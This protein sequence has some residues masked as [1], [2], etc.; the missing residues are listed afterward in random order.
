[1]KQNKKRI[2]MFA[3]PNGS[4]KSTIKGSISSDLLGYYINPDEIEKEI[5]D[6]GYFDLK[7]FDL[8]IIP[9]SAMQFFLDSNFLS[10][11][12]LLDDVSKIKFFPSKIDFSRLKINSYFASVLADFLRHQMLLNGK[13]FSFETVMSSVDKVQFLSYAQSLG[14]RTYLY[15]VAT[16]DPEINSDRVRQRV[17]FG[18]HDVPKDKIFSRYYRS[19]DL[20]SSAIKVTNRAYIFDNSSESSIWIAEITNASEI[21]L[22]V[23]LLPEW[24]E[25]YVWNKFFK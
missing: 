9:S 20:L 19:L 12:G 25:K 3:G 13:S 6:F 11:T 15:Y 4:G 10:I 16:N 18:G 14:Y 17:I 2:R 8:E 5:N 24:F 7:K 22:K 21:E 1:M 23:S